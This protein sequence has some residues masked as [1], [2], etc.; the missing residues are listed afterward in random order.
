MQGSAVSEAEWC[1]M[2]V[3]QNTQ[4]GDKE[5][6]H[7]LLVVIAKDNFVI[8][9]WLAQFSQPWCYLNMLDLPVQTY[10]A[11]VFFLEEKQLCSLKYKNNSDW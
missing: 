10:N 3:L 5:I 11:L 1:L 6:Y 4:K 9:V 8:L 7:V 2:Q